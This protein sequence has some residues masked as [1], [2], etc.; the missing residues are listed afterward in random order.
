MNTILQGLRLFA[1]MTVLTG[2]L[3][4]L[5]ITVVSY[6]A[7]NDKASGSLLTNE[8]RIVGSKLIAQ[9]FTD[10]RYFW[11]RP[12]AVDYNP[13]PSGGSNLG[14][15]SGL[16]KKQFEERASRISQAHGGVDLHAIPAALLFASASGLD[17]HLSLEAVSFQIDRV[18][19][20]RNMGSNEGKEQIKQLINSLS[21][22]QP[23][24]INILILNIELDKLSE[25]KS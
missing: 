8:G 5:L 16:L 10:N 20:A 13:L 12:S 11:P 17:P 24:Y 21:N 7:F 25:G 19:K 2:F 9:K 18:A 15:T 6:I 14:P 4:P 23:R 3:Y 22:R 1:W